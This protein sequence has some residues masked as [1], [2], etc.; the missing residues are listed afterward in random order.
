MKI[1]LINGSPKHKK[2]AS[3]FL[4]S[5]VKKLAEQKCEC[6]EIK[7]NKPEPTSE[8]VAKLC[9]CDAWIVFYPLYVD[10]VPSHLVSC[11]KFLEDRKESFDKKRIYAV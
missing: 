4:S 2:S 1:A 11:L 9:E 7:M 5:L 3:G 6:F 8:S 10:G